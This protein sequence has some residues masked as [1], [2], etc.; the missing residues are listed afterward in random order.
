MTQT[1]QETQVEVKPENVVK[2]QS[3]ES[4][5]L[6]S[7]FDDAEYERWNQNLRNRNASKNQ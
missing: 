4:S 5:P 3:I 7:R 2:D 6:K 1:M